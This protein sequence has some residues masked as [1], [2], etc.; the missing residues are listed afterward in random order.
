MGIIESRDA[1]GKRRFAVRKRWPDGSEIYRYVANRTLGKQ[2]L[3]RIEE[4]ITMGTWRELREEL[5]HGVEKDVTVRQFWE[6]FRDEYC[7]PRMTSWKRYEQSFKLIN[8]R[9]GDVPL[10][11][12]NR[13]H[14]HKYIQYRK[15]QVTDSTIN[16]DIAAIKKMFSYAFEVEAVETNPLVRFKNI[17]VQETALRVLTDEE[18]ERLI[19]SMPTPEMSAFVAIVGETGMRLSEALNLKWKDVDFQ[20]DR[21][22]LEHT[23]GKR[24]R[25]VP[26][27]KKAIQKM[28]EIPKHIGVEN[29]FVRD[30]GQN[31]GKKIINPNDQFQRG[32]KAAGLEWAT[33]HGLRHYRITSWIQHGADIR[34]VQ[35][36]AGHAEIQTTMR[37]AHYV[38]THADKAIREAQEREGDAKN[39]RELNRVKNG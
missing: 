21:I 27:S 1:G 11:E 8:E 14:L 25:Y 37:Y 12:F 31:K 20:R 19:N 23:K 6:R 16:R 4:A 7:K 38:E 36:K 17:P 22:T 30:S 3:S 33:I 34:S 9:V 5:R 35:G 28:L 39:E 29:V 13:V 2:L 15:G 24:V 10:R 18:F 26:L 32:R